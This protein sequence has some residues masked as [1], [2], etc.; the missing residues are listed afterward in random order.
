MKNNKKIIMLFILSTF[1]LVGCSIGSWG[2]KDATRYVKSLLDCT[3]KNSYDDYLELVEDASESEA[4]EIYMYNLTSEAE[5][6]ASY[7][8][9]EFVTEEVEEELISL[10]KE[11]YSYA[12]YT[13]DEGKKIDNDSFIV[14]VTVE[15]ID[16]INTVNNEFES[17]AA[18]FDARYENVDVESMTDEEYEEWYA[19][20]DL[21]WCLSIIDLCKSKVA[22]IGYGEQTSVNVEVYLDSD[23]YYTISDD[24]YNIDEHIIRYY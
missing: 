18:E 16:I 6:F 7:F 17:F 23:D 2:P 1:L 21:D 15:P 19:A 9:M 24:F 5:Y 12:K 3:Y 10:L 13:V 8:G 22:S 14:K 20:Y 4:E 11:I